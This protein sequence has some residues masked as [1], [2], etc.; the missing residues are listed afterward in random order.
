[1]SKKKT[2]CEKL[3]YKVGDKFVMKINDYHK[4]GKTV[5]LERDDGTDRP[6]FSGLFV[7]LSSVNKVAKL[8]PAKQALA[9]AIHQNGGW[10]KECHWMF[11]ASNGFG[12]AFC[13]TN[14]PKRSG[15]NWLGGGKFTPCCEIGASIQN[16]HQC[17]LSRDEYFTAYPEQVNVEVG[18]ETGRKVEVEMESESE[19]TIKVSDWHKNGELPPVGAFVD[20][21]GD[22]LIYGQGESNCEVIAHVENTAVIRMSYGLGCFESGAIIPARTERDK[23][24]DEMVDV[25]CHNGFLSCDGTE[26]KKIAERLLDSGYRKE[27]KQ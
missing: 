22:S 2:P 3:G 9:D 21:V 11:A 4:Q 10:P 25:I 16:W 1:M 13:W 5:F 20:V 23:A 17:I 18:N 27:V 24:I 8:K 12:S 7:W 19:V 26:S 6:I 15:R 14:K